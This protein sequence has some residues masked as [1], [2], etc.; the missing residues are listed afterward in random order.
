MPHE[1]TRVLVPLD[2]S[3][4]GREALDAVRA[5]LRREATHVTILHVGPE[6]HAPPTESFDRRGTPSDRPLAVY[7]SQE[8]ES[9]RQALVDAVA[10]DAASLA[11]SGWKVEVAT[12]FGDAAQEIVAFA[13]SNGTDLIAMATHARRGLARAVLGSVAEAVLRQ[14]D[15]PLLIVRG[16]QQDVAGEGEPVLASLGTQTA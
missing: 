14:A 1:S 13:R 6:P 15:V 4:F 12:A 16:S 10:P 7:D 3:A 9:A 5:T 11:R 8:W 2:D